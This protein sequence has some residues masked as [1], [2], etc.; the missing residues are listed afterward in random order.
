M[1]R[2]NERVSEFE[3]Q[4]KLIEEDRHS[5]KATLHFQLEK[6][7]TQ[8]ENRSSQTEEKDKQSKAVEVNIILEDTEKINL[9]L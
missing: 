5:L 7:N 1:Q 6:K 2:A 4:L 8:R 9:Q 3:R